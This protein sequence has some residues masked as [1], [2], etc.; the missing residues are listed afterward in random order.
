MEACQFSPGPLSSGE[1]I[2]YAIRDE[3]REYVVD[4]QKNSGK[5]IV[6]DPGIE[7]KRLHVIVEEF[8]GAL[9]CSKRDGNT[10]SSIIRVVMTA[11]KL[12]L[13]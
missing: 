10:L 9:S 3:R 4:K 12:S 11:I 1:G 6:T 5:F 13:S 8:A 7:D 2:I